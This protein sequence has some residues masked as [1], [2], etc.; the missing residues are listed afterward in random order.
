MGLGQRENPHKDQQGSKVI[1]LKHTHSR[2]FFKS[3]VKVHGRFAWT[4]RTRREGI[5]S[6]FCCLNLRACMLQY[7]IPID[8]EYRTE[9]QRD[10]RRGVYKDL[11]LTH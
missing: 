10:R 1:R 8:E 3:G 9:R 4:E 7:A 5:S 2:G 6:S 11:T